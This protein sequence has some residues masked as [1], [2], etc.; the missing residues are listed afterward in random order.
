MSAQPALLPQTR[1]GR[2]FLIA[3][4]VLGVICAVQLGALGWHLVSGASRIKSSS[5]AA[6][7]LAPGQDADAMPRADELLGAPTPAPLAPSPAPAAPVAARPVVT[8]KDLVGQ[9]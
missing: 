1:S 2:T 4:I 6:A 7:P 5:T 9:A 8:T 3:A